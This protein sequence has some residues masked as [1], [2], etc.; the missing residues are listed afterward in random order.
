MKTLLAIGWIALAAAAEQ[1]APP[2]KSAPARKAA[3]AAK[4]SPWPEGVPADATKLSAFEWRHVDKQ[5]KAWIYKKTPFSVA[6]LP[7]AEY[8]ATAPSSTPPAAGAEVKDLGDSF[9]FTK[10]TPFNT[11]RWVKKKTDLDEGEKAMV[12]AAGLS[13]KKGQE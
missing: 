13:P 11:A 5:G 9:E 2:Q 10:K 7:E 12:A 3:P 8:Y 4:K 1:K 6:K